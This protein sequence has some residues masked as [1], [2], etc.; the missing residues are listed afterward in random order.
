MWFVW[1]FVVLCCFNSIVLYHKI[2]LY[3]Y[4]LVIMVMN[5]S[6]LMKFVLEFS[7]HRRFHEIILNLTLN[8][9]VQLPFIC[10]LEKCP[11]F[12]HFVHFR[13]VFSFIVCKQIWTV[14]FPFVLS[15]FSIHDFPF[16]FQSKFSYFFMIRSVL[17]N[18]S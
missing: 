12:Q 2:Y 16:I 17:N 9:E 7:I 14:L 15:L 5:N 4:E 11:I 13:S 6:N 10:S 18:K 3:I 8:P 1:T